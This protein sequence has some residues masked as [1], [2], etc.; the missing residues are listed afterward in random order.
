[1]TP[2]EIISLGDISISLGRGH[3]Q[4][5]STG[6]YLDNYLAGSLAS[7]VRNWRIYADFAQRLISIARPLSVDEP[8]GVDVRESVYA[9]DTTSLELCLSVFPWAAFRST[10][11]AVKLH[12]VL[13]LRGHTNILTRLL[14]HAGASISDSSCV[15]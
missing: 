10:K 8:F 15:T 4:F 1:M 12:T 14:I 13:D 11:A 7:A 5:A 3:Y 9:L 2:F 6:N